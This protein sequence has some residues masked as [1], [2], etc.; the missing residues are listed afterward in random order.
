[1]EIIGIVILNYVFGLLGAVFRFLIINLKN[2]FLSRPITVF[3]E[4]W[5]DKKTKNGKYD[6]FTTNVI[7][8]AVLFFIFATLA[9]KFGW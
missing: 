1:M 2:L 3:K 9:I 6:N 5:R 7:T 4:V 8:G